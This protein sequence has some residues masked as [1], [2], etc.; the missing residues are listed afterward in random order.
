VKGVNFSPSRWADLMQIPGVNATTDHRRR[1]R[2][3]EGLRVN[4]E[5]EPGVTGFM[6]EKAQEALGFSPKEMYPIGK[7]PRTEGRRGYF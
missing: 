7:L 5:A 3:R 2:R 1:D 6:I 4:V